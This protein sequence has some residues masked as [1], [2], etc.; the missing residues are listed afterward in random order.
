MKKYVLAF[1]VLLLL[2]TAGFAF[3]SEADIVP[4]YSQREATELDAGIRYYCQA[5]N[6]SMWF[7]FKATESAAH[8]VAFSN[9]SLRYYDHGGRDLT[10]PVMIANRYGVTSSYSTVTVPNNNEF[11]PTYA[12][13]GTTQLITFNADADKVYFI[14]VNFSASSQPQDQMDGFF[15]LSIC[16]ENAHVLA[17]NATVQMEATCE[18]AGVSGYVCTLCGQMKNLTELPAI[19]HSFGEEVVFTA[20]TCTTVGAKGR[21]CANCGER[22]IT[23]HL[24]ALGHVAGQPVEVRVPTCTEDGDREYHCTVCGVLINREAVPALGHQPDEY[25]V[26]VTASCETNGLRVQYCGVCAELLHERPIMAAGHVPGSMQVVRA[27]TCLEAGYAEQRCVTCGIVMDTE[28]IAALG[29]APGEFV[30]LRPSALLQTGLMIS[31]CQQCGEIMDSMEL[32]AVGRSQI[33]LEHPVRFFSDRRDDLH[34]VRASDME[35][36]E[37]M[38]NNN[39]IV[40]LQS[41]KIIVEEVDD[42]KTSNLA[43]VPFTVS[44]CVPA[45]SCFVVDYTFSLTA[46]KRADDGTALA[47]AKLIDLGYVDTSNRQMFDRGSLPNNALISLMEKGH[48]AVAS[49]NAVVRVAFNNDADEPQVVN[50]YFA[51]FAGV[52]KAATYEHRLITELTVSTDLQDVTESLTIDNLAEFINDLN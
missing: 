6:Q 47:M 23:E 44:V 43:Y 37:S 35:P 29:H 11:H 28:E 4:G 46:C 15:A 14:C 26:S 45:N 40:H 8:T 50:H 20:A 16:S 27:A 48:N 30:Q 21:I 34:V 3:A 52:D 10:V 31:S 42:S 38:T 25:F 12:Q 33:K 49:G 19:G 24:A 18:T 51:L 7:S 9:L 32:P 17:E 13:D 22:E 2:C 5:S 39:M 1:C 41:N 36:A